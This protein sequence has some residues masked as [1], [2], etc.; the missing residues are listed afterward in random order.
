MET[1]GAI[2]PARPLHGPCVVLARAHLKLSSPMR[3]KA[4]ALQDSSFR[5]EGIINVDGTIAGTTGECIEW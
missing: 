1:I 5:K 2:L 4:W 3:L